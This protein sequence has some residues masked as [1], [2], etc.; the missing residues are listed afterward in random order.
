MRVCNDRVKCLG[1]GRGD[2]VVWMRF[3]EWTLY[4]SY[5]FPNKTLEKW[6]ELLQNVRTVMDGEQ[7]SRM[8]VC[9]ITGVEVTYP[10]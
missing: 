6:A 7:N 4:Q 5:A 8:I 2:G 1:Y 3:E 9:K 10:E